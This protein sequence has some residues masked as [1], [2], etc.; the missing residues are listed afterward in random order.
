MNDKQL[1][2][3]IEAIFRDYDLETESD[4][5]D[6]VI[7]LLALCKEYA[8]SVLPEEDMPVRR[9]IVS[10]GFNK[11]IKQAKKNIERNS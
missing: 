2:K 11:A 8:L 5:G 4:D 7:E 3:K 9:S 1:K 6:A 10:D